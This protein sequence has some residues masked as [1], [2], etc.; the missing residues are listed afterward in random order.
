MTS[1]EQARTED[2]SLK[3]GDATLAVRRIDLFPDRPHIVFLHD[4]LGCIALWRDFP[5]VLARASKCNALVFDRRGYG[6]SSPFRPGATRDQSYL[7]RDTDDFL[8]FIDALGLPQAPL[9]FGHSDGGT[10]ALLSAARRPDYFPAI[11]TEGAHVFVED[12]TLEGI[13]AAK[14]RYA[15]TN[16]LQRL[17]KYHG[18]KA[19]DVFSA[20]ADTW[21]N[22]EYRDWNIEEHLPEVQCPTLVLQGVDDE[23]GTEAQV[24][25]IVSQ[26]SGSASKAMIVGAKHSPHKE[27][28]EATLAITADFIEKSV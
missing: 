10:I 11:I 7:D 2:F 1:T 18:D 14:Q 28:A 22:P 23:F 9:L 8:A 27:Q 24:D 15:T 26:V 17:E 4:S 13:R 25:A 3:L 21:L 19:A 20:W 16:F 12:L 5:E 6:Q